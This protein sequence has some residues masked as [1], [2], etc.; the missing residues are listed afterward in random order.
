[1]P[2]RQVILNIYDEFWVVDA[3]KID[4][5]CQKKGGP[6][7][8]DHSFGTVAVLRWCCGRNTAYCPSFGIRRLECSEQRLDLF[9]GVKPR[10]S[11]DP[12]NGIFRHIIRCSFLEGWRKKTE[13][14]LLV[15]VSMMFHS[16]LIPTAVDLARLAVTLP[17]T[18]TKCGVTRAAWPH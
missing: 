6:E 12:L 5:G 2:T 9:A 8:S 15:V 11:G 4:F 10:P 16:L 7:L 13:P 18:L 1:M 14:W 17:W 3:K